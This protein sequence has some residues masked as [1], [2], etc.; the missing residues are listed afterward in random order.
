MSI[1]EKDEINELRARLKCLEDRE[2]LRAILLRRR[3]RGLDYKYI[4]GK[5][6]D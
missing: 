3:A 6:R 5:S 2:E 1:D 4:L